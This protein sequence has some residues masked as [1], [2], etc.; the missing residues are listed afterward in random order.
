MYESEAI[1]KHLYNNYGP[2]EAKIPYLLGPAKLATRNSQLGKP[3]FP[4]SNIFS[5]LR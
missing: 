5:V 3:P 4:L 1:L 2:G